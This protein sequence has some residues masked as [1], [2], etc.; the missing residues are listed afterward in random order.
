[1]GPVQPHGV[2]GQHGRPWIMME[3]HLLVAL[4]RAARPRPLPSDCRQPRGVPCNC[5]AGATLSKLHF[6][7]GMLRHGRRW[8][9]LKLPRSPWVGAHTNA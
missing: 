5:L 7:S 3:M 4:E 2:C 8:P 1:M 6:A 9:H